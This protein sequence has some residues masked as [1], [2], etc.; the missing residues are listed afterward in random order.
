MGHFVLELLLGVVGI[1]GH[2]PRFE[3]DPPRI[4]PSLTTSGGTLARVVAAFLATALFLAGALWIA[5]WLT[6][7]LL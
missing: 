4:E 6:L 3:N 2:I 7:K 5:V 1:R